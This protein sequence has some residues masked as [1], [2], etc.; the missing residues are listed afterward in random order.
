MLFTT[1]DSIIGSFLRS[2][3]WHGK[4]TGFW[5]PCEGT[6]CNKWALKCKTFVDASFFLCLPYA[7]LIPWMGGEEEHG[8][9]YML[10]KRGPRQQEQTQRQW[11]G[12]NCSTVLTGVTCKAKRSAC[13]DDDDEDCERTND[14]DGKRWALS[15]IH[16]VCI[17]SIIELENIFT[18][19]LVTV[20]FQQSLNAFHEHT[21]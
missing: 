12:T 11:R 13:N 15:Y 14:G 1:L 3:V 4:G 6:L 10:L 20:A 5:Y 7:Q 19:F 18:K 2:L 8:Y 17:L 21:L 16:C 9:M